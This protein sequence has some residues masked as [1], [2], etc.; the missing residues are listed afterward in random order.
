MDLEKRRGGER[1]INS[2]RSE[3]LEG[4]HLL[5]RRAQQVSGYL[6]SPRSTGP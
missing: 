3:G 1:R 2:I 6:L 4:C 5:I